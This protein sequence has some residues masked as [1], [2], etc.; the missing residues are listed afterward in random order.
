MEDKILVSRN[1][2]ERLISDS[3]ILSALEQGGVED[4]DWY[5]QS[6]DDV[7]ENEDVLKEAVQ[8]EIEN[9]REA[10]NA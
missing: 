2:L 10:A 9:L 4:W 5:Y 3:L 7:Y 1:V 6:I 8:E